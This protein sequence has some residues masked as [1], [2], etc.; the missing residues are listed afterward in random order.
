MQ[1]K[2]VLPEEILLE[3]FSQI[4]KGDLQKLFEISNEWRNLLIRNVKVMRK[5]PLILMN[6]TWME[7]NRFVINYGKYIRKIE[8]VG[9]NLESFEDVLKILRLTP[10]VEKL[11]MINVKVADKENIKS[12]E[13]DRNDENISPEK[14][15]LKRLEE[16][17]VED[18]ENVGSMKFIVSRCAINLRSLKISLKHETQLPIIEQLLTENHHLKILEISTNLDAVF[19]INTEGLK[20]QLRKLEVKAT[21]MKYNEEFV[22]FLT[23]Q[24]QLS[25]IGLIAHHV[26]FRYHQMMFT[27]FP[28]VKH[29]HLNI[30]ELCTTDCFKKLNK[31]PPNK[32]LK[33]LTLLGKNLHLNI[34]DSVLRMCPNISQLSVRSLAH[35]YSDKIKTLPLTHLLADCAH[36]EYSKLDDMTY[37]SKLQF[38]D[39]NKHQQGEIYERNLHNFCDFSGF[40]DKTKDAI[41]AF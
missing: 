3:I 40:G 16:V 34:F 11:S 22:K 24:S 31:V 20:L 27:S 1:L 19:N 32:S 8:F 7:K 36:R 2:N 33:S 15:I 13:D 29:I 9:A 21:V 5:L 35:F 26:D 23:S 14:L 41:E 4:D 17:V 10:N 30:D 25:E 38:T 39:I 18:D 37:L 12:D 28:Q 6:D